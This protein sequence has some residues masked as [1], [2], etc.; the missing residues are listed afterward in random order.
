MSA[1]PV[2]FTEVAVTRRVYRSGEG[3]YKLNGS[4]LPPAATSS[5]FSATPASARRAIP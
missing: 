1:L 5:T 3:E 4:A 2:E